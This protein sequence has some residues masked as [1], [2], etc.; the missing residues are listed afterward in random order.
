MWWMLQFLPIQ[1]KL[2]IQRI[3]Q[4]LTSLGKWSG[5]VCIRWNNSHRIICTGKRVRKAKVL[6][7]QSCL[8]LNNPMDCSL[9]GSSAHEILQA[10]ILE[11][12]AISSFR[13]SSQSRNQT[14]I[15]CTAG[16]FFTMWAT[17]ESGDPGKEQNSEILQAASSLWQ[18]SV[19]S[20]WDLDTSSE[21]RTWPPSHKE[22]WQDLG[23]TSILE[24]HSLRRHRFQD[25]PLIL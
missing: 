14:W 9:P 22:D 24:E 1:E 8:T 7:A 5:L 4:M 13:G 25:M 15:S 3:W 2:R 19:S 16:R 11:F 17:G 20:C 18:A 10:R 6:V 23:R 12:V 21:L